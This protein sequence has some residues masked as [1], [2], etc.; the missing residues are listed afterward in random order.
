G[1]ERGGRGDL[2]ERDHDARLAQKRQLL[3]EKGLASSHLEGRR[4]VG[5]RRA[6]HGR[7]DV[8][9][10]EREA[11]A[12]VR[13]RREIREPGRVEGL[14]EPVA[15]LIARE[16][17]A[18]AVAAVGGGRQSDEHDAS[19]RVAEARKWPRP[20]SLAAVAAERAPAR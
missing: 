19:A 20:I 12:R 13:R 9:A 16:D 2:A 18:G 10:A 11:V 4:L 3:D 5:G 8:G 1:V 15:A 6:A 17:A 14:V 7:G